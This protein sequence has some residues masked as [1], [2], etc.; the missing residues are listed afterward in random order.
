MWRILFSV[1]I[2]LFAS[3]NLC[4]Q[5]LNGRWAGELR[6]QNQSE[7]FDYT[8]EL[9]QAGSEV[10]GVAVSQS[11][12]G[13]ISARFEIGGTWG[14]PELV[15]QEVFQI[16]PANNPWC[17]KH[18]SLSYSESEGIAYLEGTWE[19]EN[20]VPGTLK[21][22]KK[23]SE[24]TQSDTTGIQKTKPDLAPEVILETLT[25]KWAGHLTQFDREY[26]FYFE[27]KLNADGTGTSEIIS[28]GE[29]GNAK[30]KLTWTYNKNTRTLQFME[31]SLVDKSVDNWRWCL[32][33]GIL[34]FKKEQNRLSL[35]GTWTGFI[36][37]FSQ[38]SGPCAPG[39]LYLEQPVIEPRELYKQKELGLDKKKQVRPAAVEEYIKV[40][41]R[42]VEVKRVVEVEG[43][44]VKIRVWD[45]GTIDGDV[46]SLFLNG[47]LL[48]KNHRA[49]R[50]K[51]EILVTLEK[52]VNYLILHAI[53]LGSITPNTVA[54][55]VDD[56]R[57]E[58]V[59]MLSSS[60]KESGAIMIREFR[61]E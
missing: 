29:G 2:F 19:A 32:K 9:K 22:S 50:R 26:G 49:V 21:L 12:K 20:C 47:Q 30:Q 57:G 42:E 52:P 24:V 7:V 36:E 35:E 51:L 39:S 46:L 17:L 18:I 25:G 41:K 38:E 43:R 56:G 16:E 14:A 33:S 45:N 48:L 58:Q 28:D 23:L 5:D 6:Q 11:R 4:S 44:Q 34:K 1:M 55:S 54:V 60:L 27:M 59:I 61:V 3:Q 40:E 53:N 10:N 31:T 13:G 15:L 37:G 8:L